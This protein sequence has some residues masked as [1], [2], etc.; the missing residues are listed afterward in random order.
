M[1]NI[2][3]EPIGKRIA[4]YDNRVEIGLLKFS[5]SAETWIID[6]ISVDEDFQGQGIGEQLLDRCV[7][8]AR[9]KGKKVIPLCSYASAKFAEH[10]EKYEDVSR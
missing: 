9:K 10:P 2:I 1:I 7:D 4:A 8:E 6:T 3:Y 5:P